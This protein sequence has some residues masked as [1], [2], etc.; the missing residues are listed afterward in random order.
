V[1]HHDVNGALDL[2]AR[3]TAVL[4]ALPIDDLPQDLRT[5]MIAVHVRCIAL[6]TTLLEVQSALTDEKPATRAGMSLH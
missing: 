6:S 4:D 5:R 3:V 2:L 1:T